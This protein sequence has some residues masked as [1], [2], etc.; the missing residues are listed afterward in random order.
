M[1]NNTIYNKYSEG[2]KVN[3]G[4][5]M[6]N[7]EIILELPAMSGFAASSRSKFLITPFPGSSVRASDRSVAEVPGKAFTEV[8][9]RSHQVS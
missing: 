6:P 3:E 5:P 8:H 4:G 2:M 1:Y 7:S 9:V